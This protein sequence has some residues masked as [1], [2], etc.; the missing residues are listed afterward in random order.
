ML[1]G[2]PVWELMNELLEE[3]ESNEESGATAE[4]E[5][6]SVCASLEEVDNHLMQSGLREVFNSRTSQ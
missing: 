1:P 5:S 4:S 2:T 3:E 6:D